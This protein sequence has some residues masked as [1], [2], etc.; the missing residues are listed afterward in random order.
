[1]CVLRWAFRWL[2]LVYILV[3]PSWVQLWIVTFFLP[4]LLRPR[5]FKGTIGGADESVADPRP[6][7][8]ELDDP[9]LPD[10]PAD[11]KLGGV[12]TLTLTL[13]L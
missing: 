13:R 7:L 6:K 3:Q 4:H 12:I 5:F 10:A 1:M 9:P 2:D 11:V 8:T